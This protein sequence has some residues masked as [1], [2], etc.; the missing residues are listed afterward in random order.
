MDMV[1]FD[2]NTW[3][4]EMFSKNVQHIHVQMQCEK[5]GNFFQMQRKKIVN[6]IK[7]RYTCMR[8]IVCFFVKKLISQIFFVIIIWEKFLNFHTVIRTSTG[9]QNCKS[10]CKHNLIIVIYLCFVWMFSEYLWF[11]TS[12]FQFPPTCLLP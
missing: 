6:S 12:I 10:H 2:E 8:C 11:V 4:Y 1:L 7:N 3:Y 5:E 9:Q